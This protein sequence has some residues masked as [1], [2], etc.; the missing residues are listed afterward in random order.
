MSILV[1][2]VLF[3]T[4]FSTFIFPK[5]RKLSRAS[6]RTDMLIMLLI[7][8]HN[9]ML[10]DDCHFHNYIL[11]LPFLNFIS[12]H[13]YFLGV[14]R[15]IFQIILQTFHYIIACINCTRSI[16]VCFFSKQNWFHFLSSS[17]NPIKAFLFPLNLLIQWFI[18]CLMISM[19][20]PNLTLQ[21][22]LQWAP[23]KDWK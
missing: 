20:L 8:F 5:L 10:L 15:N 6:D 7:I 4:S 12:K 23:L 13:E 11:D 19:I 16:V 3:F 2:K 1:Y 14:W 22:S 17:R 9:L 21:Q 18:K